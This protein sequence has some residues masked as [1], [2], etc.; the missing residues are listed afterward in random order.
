[1]GMDAPLLL[2]RAQ[3]A[4][5]LGVS[6]TTVDRWIAAKG[7]PA[8]RLDRLVR[9]PRDALDLWIAEQLRQAIR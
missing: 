5:R 1:M 7:L 9:I 2:T 6:L 4:E 8:V 3:A